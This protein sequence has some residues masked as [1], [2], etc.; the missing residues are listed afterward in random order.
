MNYQLLKIPI[1]LKYGS[2]IRARPKVISCE[3][4][5]DF[6]NYVEDGLNEFQIFLKTLP[7]VLRECHS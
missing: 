2:K 4:M 1:F 5:D 7:P 6:E 3:N